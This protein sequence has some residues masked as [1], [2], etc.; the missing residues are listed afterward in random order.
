MD[1]GHV[2]FHTRED[3]EEHLYAGDDGKHVAAHPQHHRVVEK[4]AAAADDGPADAEKLHGNH[5]VGENIGGI[6]GLAGA[7][8]P[9]ALETSVKDVDGEWEEEHDIG[10]GE[11][12]EDEGAGRR[13]EAAVEEVALR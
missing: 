5:M 3:V 13:V 12:R 7:A 4:G 9:P 11:G 6:H 8:L 1:H 10:D 2:A